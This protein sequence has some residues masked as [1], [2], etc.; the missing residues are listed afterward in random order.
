[1][2]ADKKKKKRNKSP[3]NIPLAEQISS[4]EQQARRNYRDGNISKARSLCQKIL[5]TP[6]NH[7]PTLFLLG[8][9]SQDE[10]SIKEAIVSFFQA[11][12]IAPNN[13]MY[14]HHLAL[15]L[16]QAGQNDQALSYYREALDINPNNADALDKIGLLLQDK[17]DFSAAI[18]HHQ[19][20]VE[21]SPSH[22]M[23]RFHL[24]KAHLQAGNPHKAIPLLQALLQDT[25]A[26]TKALIDL[27]TAYF[28]LNKL[29]KARECFQQAVSQDPTNQFALFKL[30][31]VLTNQGMHKKGL[32]LLQ[33]ALSL[34]MNTASALS[35]SPALQQLNYY[36]D[37]GPDEIFAAHK[38]LMSHM[39]RKTSS[40]FFFTQQ[41]DPTRRLRIGYV[42]PN[43]YRHSVTYF[44]EAILAT[45]RH[46]VFEIFCYATS[47]KQDEVTEKISKSA[48]I[49]REIWALNDEQVAKVI[50]DDAIDILIDLTGHTPGNRLPVFAMKPAPI[51]ISYLGYPNTS[52]LT[53]IDYRL[54]DNLADPKGVTDKWHSEKLVRFPHCFLC[55]T[56]PA[57]CSEVKPPPVV[58]KG[59]ITY[60][61]FNN[62]AKI[63]ETVVETWARIL[64]K[65]PKA[66]LFLKNKQLADRETHEQI[67]KIFSRHGINPERIILA[68]MTESLNEHL[69]LYGEIDIALDTFPYNGTTTTCEALWMGVPVITLAGETHAGRVGVSLLTTMGLDT[70]ITDSIDAYIEKA[71]QLAAESERLIELRKSMREGMRNSP[72]TDAKGFTNSLEDAYRD[73]WKKWCAQQRLSFPNEQDEEWT[74]WGGSTTNVTAIHIDKADLL[75]QSGEA[76]FE[77]QQ[78]PEAIKAFSQA[79][80]LE[81]KHIVARNN[82]GATYWQTGNIEQAIECF[83]KALKID[84]THLNA[85]HNLQEALQAQEQKHKLTSNKS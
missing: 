53:E 66:T 27:G 43:F 37:L 29:S 82:M 7:G 75:N 25:P 13:P 28:S 35:L 45:H 51:Q 49:W 30:S 14:L 67:L 36:N 64:Q 63:N 10:G 48:D 68:P 61:S 54:T 8:R 4:L 31:S 79:I 16:H 85:R 44:L 57:Q 42:S 21:L 62:L 69:D 72:L 78:F 2:A 84:P 20:A 12:S 1:M 39:H 70:L 50:H 38:N 76:F 77:N 74:N 80:A 6:G 73:M 9:I 22:P 59:H 52:G 83:Q 65:T 81:N 71:V 17:G 18:E 5:N 55:Y 11:R 60:G 46:D 24:A 23:A 3:K 56:P 47:P 40:P 19:K 15:A 32:E 41:A 58:S 34:G 26:H 33:K